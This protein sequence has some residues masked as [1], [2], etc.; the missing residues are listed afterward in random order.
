MRTNREISRAA[1][2]LRRKG[3]RTSLIQAEVIEKRLTE[4]AVFELYVTNVPA[5][6]KDEAAFFAARDAARYVAGSITLEELAP[7]VNIT[8]RQTESDTPGLEMLDED[9]IVVSKRMLYNLLSRVN[10][11]E[12]KVGIRKTTMKVN[13]KK[14]TGNEPEDLI[15]QA[16]VVRLL[17]CGKSTVKRWA[18][19]GYITGYQ[20]DG[21]VS[22][23]KKE[24]RNSQVIKE[25]LIASG[26]DKKV[27]L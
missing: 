16:E 15:S 7:D 12:L 26:K 25:Y 14:A 18:D 27:K 17:G 3:D 24:I 19:R 8:S 20:K 13:R 5:E 9:R 21:H 22:Y 1:A 4:K 2:L 10:R 11:L 6:E 23:S